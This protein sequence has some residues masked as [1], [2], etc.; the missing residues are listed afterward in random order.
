MMEVQD[1]IEMPRYV[2]HKK[3]RALKI[4][5]VIP[6]LL[7]GAPAVQIDF[8]DERY[9]P[10][11]LSTVDK[12]KPQPGWYYINYGDYESFSPAAK[13]EEGYTLESELKE[14]TKIIP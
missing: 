10:K 5:S 3:V 12:P 1:A 11:V 4:R 8:T 14:K 2:C 6:T 9:A 7:Q 13:F